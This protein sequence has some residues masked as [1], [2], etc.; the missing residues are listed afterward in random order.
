MRFFKINSIVINLE[1]VCAITTSSDP[2]TVSFTFHLRTGEN[3]ISS[4][5]KKEEAEEILA[6]IM[7]NAK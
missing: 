4:T 1:D 7:E 3:I 2:K 6:Q 5:F